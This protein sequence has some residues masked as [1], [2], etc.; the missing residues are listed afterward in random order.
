MRALQNDW[1]GEGSMAPEK[2]L[3]DFTTS[4]A[5]RGKQQN[6]LAPARVIATVN[7]TISM[8]WYVDGFFVEFEF[9][10]PDMDSIE[11]RRMR[12]KTN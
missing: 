7:G 12:L 11:V 8:E 1:D 9:V 10:E 4:L 5:H 2:S 3:V 6:D